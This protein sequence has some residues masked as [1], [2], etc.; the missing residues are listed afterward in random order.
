[1]AELYDLIP[2]KCGECNNTELEVK[3]VQTL[4]FDDGIMKADKGVTK[5]VCKCSVCGWETNFNEEQIIRGLLK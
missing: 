4:Y 1:M 5:L 3:V 2:N